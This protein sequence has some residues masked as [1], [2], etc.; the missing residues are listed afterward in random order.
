M[1]GFCRTHGQVDLVISF[2]SGMDENGEMIADQCV[3]CIEECEAAT[4]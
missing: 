2:G 4:W 3:D 1:R